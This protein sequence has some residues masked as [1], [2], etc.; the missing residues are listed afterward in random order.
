MADNKVI[1]MKK[2][3]KIVTWL[4]DHSAE[5]I[6]T[7]AVIS[8]SAL[9]LA[10]YAAGVK[11]GKGPDIDEWCPAPYKTTDGKIGIT[12]MGFKNT[13]D[14]GAIM[15]DHKDFTYEKLEYARNVANNIL[16]MADEIEAN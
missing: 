10:V 12:M 4:K 9:M 1:E 13:G 8:F 2:E 5:L 11:D 3:N 14:G 15:I 7:G 16:K 6:A